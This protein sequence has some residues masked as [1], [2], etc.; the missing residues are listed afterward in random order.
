MLEDRDGGEYVAAGY[1]VATWGELDG[2]LGDERFNRG[3]GCRVV[4][5]VVGRED[6]PAKFREVFRRAGEQL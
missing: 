4:D 1:K 2:L 6:V 5:V 3:R